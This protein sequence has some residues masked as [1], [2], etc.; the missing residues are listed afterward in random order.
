[1]HRKYCEKCGFSTDDMEYNFCPKCSARL[2]DSIDKAIQ[3][4]FDRFSTQYVMKCESCSEYFQKEYGKCPLCGDNLVKGDVFF[5][6]FEKAQITSKFAEFES[7]ASFE[8]LYNH[9]YCTHWT[10][11]PPGAPVPEH[12]IFE[13]TVNYI[14]E[15][16]K[17]EFSS[18][19]S[20]CNRKH[21][22]VF[23]KCPDCGGTL[24]EFKES[25]ALLVA[26][27][28]C[29]SKKIKRCSK[30]LDEHSIDFKY[31]PACGN[32]LSEE[33]LFW[34]DE[35]KGLI[36]TYWNKKEISM[37]I[38]VYYEQVMREAYDTP[39]QVNMVNLKLYY[40][41]EFDEEL[42]K[43]FSRR[44]L[45]IPSPLTCSQMEKLVLTINNFKIDSL[46]FMNRILI[47][48][49]FGVDLGELNNNYPDIRFVK[50]RKDLFYVYVFQGDILWG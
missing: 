5:I 10:M 13:D 40:K 39:M 36:K 3:E 24:I 17:S 34:L 25:E 14:E 18:Y 16:F 11:F 15:Y 26:M 1:M 23:D 31:C 33:S 8:D 19:C 35:E 32:P 20:R 9:Y 48:M 4:I 42:E 12:A 22:S 30:C 7:S 45:K 41:E 21:R 2:V 29:E 44:D 50:L 43:S 37:P 49:N 28:L 6:D 46:G 38:D 27:K 47:Q